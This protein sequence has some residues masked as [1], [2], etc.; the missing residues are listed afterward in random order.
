MV[1][2]RDPFLTPV[3]SHSVVR[4]GDLGVSRLAGAGNAR[5][6]VGSSALQRRLHSLHQVAL[7]ILIPVSFS[8]SLNPRFL[9]YPLG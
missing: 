3:A 8:M 9:Q 4:A 7:E 2:R 5:R 6:E 1:A